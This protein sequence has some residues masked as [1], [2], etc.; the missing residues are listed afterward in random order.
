[1][2]ANSV[3]NAKSTGKNAKVVYA[4][5]EADGPIMTAD[6]VFADY[7]ISDQAFCKLRI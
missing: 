2:A 4:V 7:T 3:P 6:L 1:M 5:G